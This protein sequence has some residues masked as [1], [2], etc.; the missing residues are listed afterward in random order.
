MNL[1][2]LQDDFCSYLRSDGAVTLASVAPAAQRGLGVYHFAHRATLGAALGDVFE[3]THAWLGDARF[4]HAAARHI[5]LHPPASWTLADYGAGFEETLAGLYPDHPEVAE[6]AWLDWTLRVAFNGPDCP[7]LDLASLAGV[8]WD[9]ARLVINPTLAYRPIVTNVALI[10]QALDDGEPDP[11]PAERLPTPAVLTVW[12]QGLMPRFQTIEALEHE[13]LAVAM[14]GGSLGEICSIL[15]KGPTGSDAAATQA[16]A[17]LQR[18]M[19]E[20]VL[21]ALA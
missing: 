13:A 3:R 9:S 14:R 5:A 7:D 2:Q 21:V 17:M 6:L 11:P 20:A 1:R 16:G 19:S 8:D 15:A 12:R 10:W 18:W 4:D